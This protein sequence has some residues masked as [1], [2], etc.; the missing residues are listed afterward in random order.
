MKTK[1]LA[2]IAQMLG[3]IFV[4][5]TS[6]S[7]AQG[8]PPAYYQLGPA[9]ATLYKPD[10]GP[11]PH[12]GVVAMHRTAN[13]LSYIGCMELSKR[14]FLALCMNPRFDNNETQV[15]W[16]QMPLDVAAGVNF[17][18]SQP[19]ITKVL[20][21]GHSGGGPTMSFYQAVAENGPSYCQ[22]PNKLVECGNNLAGLPKADGIIFA[23]A[24]PGNPVVGVLRGNNPAVVN[25][26]RPDQLNP[27]LDPFDP[28][29]GY[30]PNPNESSHYSDSF[31]A[32]YFVAQAER[33]N[34]W[35][36]IALAKRALIESGVYRYPDDD[37]IIIPRAGGTFA[38]GG[39]AANLQQLDVSVHHSTVH[40]QKLLKNDGTIVKQI[41]ESVRV[42][43][44]GLAQTNP[45][46][47]N[48]TKDLTITSF[49]SANAIRATHS[50]DNIDWCSSNNSVPCAVQ[51]ISVPVLFNAMGAFY[52]IR[53]NEIHYEMAA[54]VDKDFVV[55]EG[56][57]HTFDPCTACEQFP[58]QY[59]NTVKNLFDYVAAWINARF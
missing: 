15:N 21:W 22:G 56:A 49:L 7:F 14:G 16:E 35:I 27:R 31:K 33:M 28:K 51:R 32:R 5:A 34:K 52:F 23:D 8:N 10:S 58:G 41:V 20:L 50:L 18:K 1:T 6:Q 57:L 46:F 39:G 45:T 44:P 24:H 47:D 4:V 54:S 55:I 42:A 3:L 36:D 9:K 19:G 59:S 26:N 53:D 29:N 17:L 12:V 48:G 38:G 2:S 13:F 30:N 40:P 37:S 25:E 11:A 43:S